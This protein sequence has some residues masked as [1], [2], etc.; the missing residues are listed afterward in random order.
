MNELE[1]LK[2]CRFAVDWLDYARDI[3]NFVQYYIPEGPYNSSRGELP[4]H[5]ERVPESVANARA[6]SGFHDRN[7][8]ALGHS[9]GGCAM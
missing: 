4:V 9:F 2:Q 3:I 1:R 8:V 7:V 5:L 6:L